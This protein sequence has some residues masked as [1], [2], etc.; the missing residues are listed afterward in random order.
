MAIVERNMAQEWDYSVDPPV[1]A[2]VWLSY[3]DQALRITQV[4]IDNTRGVRTFRVV[5][6]RAS[7]TGPTYTLDTAPGVERVEAVNTGQQQR[8]QVTVDSGG[9][10]SGVDY[11]FAFVG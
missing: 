9:K 6:K 10:L 1:D 4:R 2:E 11:T 8:I 3:D 7:G 5:V